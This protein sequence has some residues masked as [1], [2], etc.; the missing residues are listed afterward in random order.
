MRLLN[1]VFVIVL[2]FLLL[3]FSI[4]KISDGDTMQYLVD[5]KI[6]VNNG[7][8][9]DFCS[10]NYYSHNCL[11]AYAHE[12]FF[13]IATYIIYQFGQWNSLVLFQVTIIIAIFSLVALS[14]KF[15]H[16][17]FFS[18][19]IFIFL[20]IL[21]GM[22]RFMLRA[23]LFGILLAVLFYTVFR[24]YLDKKW[25]EKKSIQKFIPLIILFVIQI[26]WANSHGS[27]PLAFVIVL[28]YIFSYIIHFLI[29]DKLILEKDEV[30]FL[31]SHFMA[32]LSVLIVSLFASIVNP[33]GIRAFFDAFNVSS[34][35][36]PTIQEWQSPFTSGDYQAFS[37]VIYTITL[38]TAIIIISINFVNYKKLRIA[39]IIILLSFIYLSVSYRR[40]IAIFAI[41]CAIILPYY[42]DEI[43]GLLNKIFGNKQNIHRTIIIG[44]QIVMVIIIIL[45]IYYMYEVT[46][47]TFYL[48]DQRS[49]RFGIGLSENFFPISAAN[50]IE[51]NNIKGNMF[52]DYNI[53]TYLN[54]R[55]YPIRKTFIDEHTFSLDSLDYYHKIM[56]GDIKYSDITKKYNINYF[57]LNHTNPNTATLITA[58]YSDKKWVLVYFDE[59]TALFVANTQENKSI[60]DK[61]A[62]NFHTNTNYNPDLLISIKDPIN[63][64]YGFRMRG[65]FLNQIGLVKEANYQFQK[66]VALGTDD[67]QAYSGLGVTYAEMGQ[68]NPAFEAFTKAASLEPNYAPNHYNLGIYYY[69]KGK[70][71]Q[72]LPEFNQALNIN[73]SYHEANFHIGVIYQKE[74][75][76]T[77]AKMYYQKELEINPSATYAQN[78]LKAL[79]N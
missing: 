28:A 63:F 27:F 69:N 4:S 45:S 71:D 21:V 14:S 72:A 75:D 23:D 37:L 1:W 11:F 15:F 25:Y 34:F 53:G 8:N 59:I 16:N 68:D 48:H 46:T 79:P 42:L 38:F 66:A 12:W 57:I 33:Y 70:Y 43:F 26:I 55:F 19:G 40:N 50:F 78:A 67:N 51:N 56:S 22:E 3:I 49:R 77:N 41:F 24:Y 58:L 74:G 47:N 76:T 29:I 52:N 6:M 7:L 31:N 5:G 20:A 30:K 36:S 13:D 54:W 10:F 44:K 32:L 64:S 39:D 73:N 60:I 35:I 9:S 18:T 17:T 61:Y 2:F 65:M 62:V